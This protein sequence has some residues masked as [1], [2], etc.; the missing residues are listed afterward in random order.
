MALDR[1][2]S[3]LLSVDKQIKKLTKQLM[4]LKE[5]RD[6]MFR[7]HMIVLKEDKGGHRG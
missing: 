3:R 5:E 7:T 4:K 1:V 2:V 6:R